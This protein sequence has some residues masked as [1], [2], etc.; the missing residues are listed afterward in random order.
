MAKRRH[1]RVR[2]REARTTRGWQ[3][4]ASHKPGDRAELYMRCGARAFLAPNSRNP[5]HSKFP[6][7]PKHGP[8]EVDC[9]GLRA[10]KARAHQY[11]HYSA[12][13]KAESLAKRAHCSWV[14]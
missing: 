2:A 10:A 14:D 9:R 8:C 5:G 3:R 6:I 12:A 7:M 1:S 4:Q 11:G 13:R